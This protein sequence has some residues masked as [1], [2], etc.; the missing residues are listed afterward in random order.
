M[1]KVSNMIRY[2]PVHV[3]H[4]TAF[5]LLRLLVSLNSQHSAT[6]LLRILDY[7]LL[8]PAEIERIQF[9]EEWRTQWKLHFRN[10][11]NKY[12]STVSSYSVFRQLSEPQSV[13]FSLLHSSGITVNTVGKPDHIS[14]STESVPE[15]ISKQILLRNSEDENLMEF[16]TS[17]LGTLDMHEIKKRTGLMEYRY[18]AI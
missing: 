4:H 6:S 14:L 17:Y 7:Y 2:H 11:A 3:P 18:D 13:A 8:F 9:P 16:L 12:Y 10:Y 1:D 5:R 15:E